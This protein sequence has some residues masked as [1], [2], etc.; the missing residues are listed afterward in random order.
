MGGSVERSSESH[1]FGALARKTPVLSP[2]LSHV[3][4]E[5]RRTQ[6]RAARTKSPAAAYPDVNVIIDEAAARLGVELSS[7]ERDEVLLHVEGDGQPFGILQPL[8][9]D[10]RVTD[11][12][13]SSY[14]KIAVQQGRKNIRTQ[15]RFADSRTYEAFV[16][17]L[18]HRAGTSYSTKQP[19]ADGMIGALVRVHV[20][21]SS[22][23]EEG[24]YLTIRINR[25]TSVSLADLCAVGLAPRPVLEYLRGL[26]QI[27]ATLMVVGEVGT[28]KTT[29]ARA[30]AGT[31][32]HDD[33]VLVIEDTPEIRLDH[34]HVRY[35]TTREANLEGAGRVSPA[36]CIRAGMRMAMNRIIFGEIRDAEAAEAF[37]DVCASGHPGLS[38]IHGRSALDAVVRLE[39]FLARAQKGSEKAMLSA[40]VVTAVQVVVVV[41][42]CKST[43]MRRIVEVRELGP[44]ADGVLRQREVFAYRVKNGLPQWGVVHRVSAFREKIE[45]LSPEFSF[46]KLP[47]V[48]ELP[49]EVAYREAAQSLAR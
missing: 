34:P 47:E 3:L 14:S 17:R 20:V 23:C 11:I 7:F 12:I 46:A 30:L 22:L 29:L 31:I 8:I 4:D 5:V 43:G 35:I 19:I 32:P 24:P 33:S 16:E 48:L 27:G 1:E 25:Y 44:F 9:D 10:V 42:L 49:L 15:L 38:T 6:A 39:L 26:I 40:Q 28:G 13:V 21:H 41:G 37:V 45:Q 18:L 36:Q 2:V